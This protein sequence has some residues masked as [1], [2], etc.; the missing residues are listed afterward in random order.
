VESVGWAATSRGLGWFRLSPRVGDRLAVSVYYDQ[1]GHVFYT[2]TDLTRPATQTVVR[3]VGRV[4]YSAAD[5]WVPIGL[6]VPADP[7][8]ADTRLWQFTGSRLTTYSGD[9]G[10]ITGPWTTRKMITTSTGTASGT[11]IV[12]P[13]G[14][15]AGGRDFSAWLRALPVSYNAAHVGYQARGRSFRFVTTTLTVPPRVL[16]EDRLGDAVIELRTTCGSQC[17]GPSA[18]ID[19][20]P[21]GG[22]GSV[23]YQGFF[24]GGQF[25]VSP[26]VGDRLAIS[27]YY[28]QRGHDYFTVADLTQHTT[29][30]VRQSAGG[31]NP[32]FDRAGL[33]AVVG[34]TAPRPP[35]DMGLWQ[36]TGTHL[37]TYDGVHG[38]VLGP[39]QTSTLVKT[40]DG[41]PAGTVVVSP[42]G[43]LN[44]GQ[45]FGVWLRHQQ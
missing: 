2:V 6:G 1:R 32:V 11:V 43:L 25:L 34:G 7:P 9:R 10:T 33:Y 30:T 17:Q 36:F 40:S 37:T 24:T 3:N 8:A 38:T 23:L 13:S 14:L 15:S 27:I 26:Q 18:E 5:L 19:V 31:I 22:R 4:V 28:D 45:D 35:A 21:G 20:L 29:Q 16:P 41:T 12:S 44:G 42:S 39:W